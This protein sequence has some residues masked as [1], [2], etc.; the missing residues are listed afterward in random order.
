MFC[1]NCGEE[2][3][4]GAK[5]CKGCGKAL[6][7]SGTDQGAKK[8]NSAQGNGGSAVDGTGAKALKVDVSQ[9]TKKI[10]ALPKKV[11]VG[12]LA[13]AVALIA[14]VC[15]VNN[16]GRTINLN[17]YLTVESTGY[18]GYGTVSASIDWNAIEEKYGDRISFT[19][20][21][22]SEYGGLITMMTPVDAIQE[23]VSV[24]LD[25]TSGLSNGDEISY[26]WEVDEE[27]SEYVKCKIKYKDDTYSVSGLS[28]VETFDAFAELEVTFSGVAPYGSASINYNGSELSYYDF[29]CNNSN[30]LSNG[31][32]IMVSIDESKLKYYAEKSGKVPETTQKEYMVEGLNRWLSNVSEINEDALLSI[33]QQA[34]DVF[35]AYVAQNWGEGEALDSFTYIGNYLLTIKNSDS[36]GSKNALY[37]IYKAQVKNNYTND[38]KTYDK[39]ND[40]YWYI[41]Y[42]DLMV[43]LDD[44]LIVEVTDYNKPNDRFMIDSGISSGW[45]SNMQWYY[46]GYQ[47]LDEL[48]QNIVTRNLDLYNHQDNVDESIAPESAVED[49]SNESGFILPNSNSNILSKED[50]EGLTAEACK[51]AR[52]EIYARHGRKFKEEDVQS[53]FD[54]CDWYEGTIEPDDFDENILTDIEIANKDFIVAYE[55]EKGYR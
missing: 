18:D 37:L 25:T 38:G 27:L 15:V 6:N 32:T 26:T 3:V 1:G 9:L 45:W 40:I 11:I 53:Y 12:I 22:K 39:L 52:N 35:N 51:I 30:G 48:Y 7:E 19:G 33:Q 21:A 29:V 55:E 46:N 54:S 23:S 13:G 4:G 50:L 34:S 28:K 49:I 8:K 16:A 31:D 42:D 36:W 17:Q 5:F 14:I 47:T 20:Q 44:K 43:G 24:R 41:S 10:K 2:N